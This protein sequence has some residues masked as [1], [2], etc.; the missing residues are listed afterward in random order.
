MVASVSNVSYWTYTAKIAYV[1]EGGKAASNESNPTGAMPITITSRG[2]SSASME[3]CQGRTKECASW[4]WSWALSVVCAHLIGLSYKSFVFPSKFHSLGLLN[5][6]KSLRRIME[7]EN[8]TQ[9]NPL[10]QSSFHL[11]LS[12]FERP[13]SLTVGKKGGRPFHSICT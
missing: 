4:R 5:I 1:G 10:P 9:N 8:N 11:S 3:G 12:H 7:G 2:G 13:L 6:S